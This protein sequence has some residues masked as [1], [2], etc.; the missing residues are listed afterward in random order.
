MTGDTVQ[1]AREAFLTAARHLPWEPTIE[2]PYGEHVAVWGT[3][4]HLADTFDQPTLWALT[5]VLRSVKDPNV[6]H[7]CSGCC[8]AVTA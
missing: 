5:A 1:E 8:T 2:T 3:L 4:L 6:E 7:D